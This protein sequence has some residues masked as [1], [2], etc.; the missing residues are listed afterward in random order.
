MSTFLTYIQFI[1][2]YIIPIAAFVLSIVSLWKS[3]RI[4]ALEKKINEYDVIIK[5][6]EADRIKEEESKVPQ[7][8]IDAR[9]TKISDKKYKLYVFNKGDADAL[10]VDYDFEKESC[11]VP[12]KNVVPFEILSPGAHFEES[13]V[14]VM[15]GTGPKFKITLSWEDNTGEKHK[16]DLIKTLE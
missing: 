6:H 7:A 10:N 13:V 8:D 16:K 3:K 12:L 4:S 11:I 2:Q 14:V 15:S 9:V 1:A 5:K